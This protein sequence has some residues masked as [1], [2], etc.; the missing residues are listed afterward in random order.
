MVRLQPHDLAALDALI[1]SKPA[2]KPS[3]PEAIRAVLADWLRT[4]GFIQSDLDPSGPATDIVKSMD[5]AIAKDRAK[6]ARRSET[7]R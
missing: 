3:R 2:A 1:A 5:T 7:A 6:P 4:H